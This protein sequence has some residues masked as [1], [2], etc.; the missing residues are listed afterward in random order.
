MKRMIAL[1][2]VGMFLIV[3]CGTFAMGRPDVPDKLANRPPGAPTIMEDKSAWEQEI[4]KCTFYSVDPDGDKVFYAIKWE[5]VDDKV[6]SSFEPD[7]PAVPWRGPFTSGEEVIDTHACCESGDYSMTVFAKD[8]HGNVGPS[9]T[10]T[11]TYK[12]AKM[13]QLP[14]FA[15]LLARFPGL[16]YILTKVFKF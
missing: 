15:H 16:V 5:K 3:G 8:D 14:V 7:D 9:T 10:V 6:V 2:I 1:M 13:L 12:K 11:V 4:Y